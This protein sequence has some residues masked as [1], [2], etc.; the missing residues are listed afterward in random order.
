M[1]DDVAE[2]LRVPAVKASVQVGR[3]GVVARPGAGMLR[4]VAP[5]VVAAVL[6]RVAGA[7]ACTLVTVGHPF[8]VSQPGVDLCKAWT[9]RWD[10]VP[11]LHHEGVHPGWAIFRTRQE[12]SGVDHLDHFLIAVTVIR[13]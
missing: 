8:P 9:P 1:V 4:P 13:L 2:G 10:L 12:L 5:D 3:A 6:G 11:A 7:V